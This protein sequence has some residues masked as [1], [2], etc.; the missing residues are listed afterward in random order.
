MS[1]FLAY[2]RCFNRFLETKNIFKVHDQYHKDYKLSLYRYSD[3]RLQILYNYINKQK[4][5]DFT[6]ILF[7]DHGTRFSADNITLSKQMGNVGFFIKDKKIKKINK[8]KIIQTVDIFPSFF[9]RYG[10]KQNNNME[11]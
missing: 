9:E 5:D 7:G 10:E 1:W 8:K 4:Y 6:I 3:S 2:I 11:N